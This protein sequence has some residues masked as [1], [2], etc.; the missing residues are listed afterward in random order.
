M[1]TMKVITESPEWLDGQVTWHIRDLMF[2]LEKGY[3]FT[4][5]QWKQYQAL[6]SLVE[7]VHGQTSS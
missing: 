5:Q 3:R 1:A 4:D 7:Q 2:W 6:K